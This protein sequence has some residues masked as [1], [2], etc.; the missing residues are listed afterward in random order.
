MIST[1]RNSKGLSI[2]E[3]LIGMTIL[4]FSFLGA[5]SYLTQL[6]KTQL[7]TVDNQSS[8]HAAQL[9]LSLITEQGFQPQMEYLTWKSNTLYGP[10]SL[11]KGNLNLSVRN[12]PSYLQNPSSIA[13]I[14]NS[15]GINYLTTPYF[16]AGAIADIQTLYRVY[17]N[18]VC[19]NSKG[20]ELTNFASNTNM[21]SLWRN[22]GQ[23]LQRLQS[24]TDMS[25]MSISLRIQPYDIDTGGVLATCPD[26]WTTPRSSTSLNQNLY[27]EGLLSNY[28]KSFGWD[29]FPANNNMFRFPPDVKDNLGFVVIISVTQ[30]DRTSKDSLLNL[31]SYQLQQKFQY[32]F[33]SGQLLSSNYPRLI[34]SSTTDS[35]FQQSTYSRPQCTQNAS[36]NMN[37]NASFGFSSSIPRSGSTILLCRDVSQMLAPN[38]CPGASDAQMPNPIPSATNS[39]WVDCKDIEICG[40]KPSINLIYSPTEYKYDLQMNSSNV[41]GCDLRLDVAAVDVSGNITYMNH[42]SSSRSSLRAYFQPVP[43]WNCYQKKKKSSG[44]SKFG[45]ALVGAVGGFL[46]GGALTGAFGFVGGAVCGYQSFGGGGGYCGSTVSGDMNSCNDQSGSGCG[47]KCEWQCNKAPMPRSPDWWAQSSS[48]TSQPPVTC[49]ATTTGLSVSNPRGTQILAQFP[50]GLEGDYISTVRFDF[51]LNGSVG[52]QTVTPSQSWVNLPAVGLTCQAHATCVATTSSAGQRVGQWVLDTSTQGT[53]FEAASSCQKMIL[54]QRV[55]I[56]PQF[57]SV[58]T[59]QQ[60]NILP[61]V[62]SSDPACYTTLDDQTHSQ[63]LQYNKAYFD[64]YNYREGYTTSNGSGVPIQNIN[65]CMNQQNDPLLCKGGTDTDGDGVSDSNFSFPVN[66]PATVEAT[67]NS[68]TAGVVS[69]TTSNKN[70]LIFS[71]PINYSGNSPCQ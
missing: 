27:Y 30:I 70:Y 43:C 54:V 16:L 7:R 4:I 39:R 44:W 34:F 46:T 9:I 17:K 62:M 2:S 26:F 66:F 24:M 61:T 41:G 23:A 10:S 57:F 6:Q 5:T 31:K 59:L 47:K 11:V 48:V 42:L 40:V 37:F 18:D 22:G 52:S 71:D 15:N 20:L 8:I 58:S 65:Y 29:L 19:A 25:S 68:S 38:W 50:Q 14:Q 12:H 49:T 51:P 56:N 32:S 45:G 28:D 33:D 64:R 3:V 36:T 13:I 55:A 21:T 67:E 63:A 1:I 60:A 69:Y 35:S 53:G